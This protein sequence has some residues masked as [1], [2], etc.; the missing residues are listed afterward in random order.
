MFS[1]THRMCFDHN[2]RHYPLLSLPSPTGPF[3]TVPFLLSC[4]L[5]L[6]L[7]YGEA[8]SLI[9]VTYR[10]RSGGLFMAIYG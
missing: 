9:R 1:Y 7:F 10:E 5:F 6:H 3:F 4:L 2:Q 8:I